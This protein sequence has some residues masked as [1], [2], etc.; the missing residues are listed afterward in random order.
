MTRQF[1]KT[2][3]SACRTVTPSKLTWT[4]KGWKR[5]LAT[6]REVEVWDAAKTKVPESNDFNFKNRHPELALIQEAHNEIMYGNIGSKLDDLPQ[7]LRDILQQPDKWFLNKNHSRFYSVCDPVTQVYEHG[8]WGTDRSQA[9]AETLNERPSASR[10]FLEAANI[11]PLESSTER[12]TDILGAIAYDKDGRDPNVY[13]SPYATRMDVNISSLAIREEDPLL[14]EE[15]SGDDVQTSLLHSDDDVVIRKDPRAA[16]LALPDISDEARSNIIE[17][18]GKFKELISKAKTEQ[19]YNTLVLTYE[20]ALD[21]EIGTHITTC[22]NSS[23]CGHGYSAPRRHHDPIKLPMVQDSTAAAEERV[24]FFYQ[25]LGE[26]ASCS[27]FNDLFGPPIIDSK[28]GRRSNP[29]GFMGKI[30]SMYHHDKEIWAKWSIHDVVDKKTGKIIY[31]SAF[32]IAREDFIRDY[33][34]KKKGDEEK[35]R[36]A[37]WVRFD[38]EETII[39]GIRDKNGK[40]VQKF[41]HY[42]DSIWR[43]KRTKA[44]MDA[45]LTKKQWDSV[46][47]MIGIARKRIK[48]VHPDS[49]DRQAALDKL[50]E[51]FRKVTNLYDLRLYM[52][53]AQKRRFIERYQICGWTKKKDGTLVTDKDGNKIPQLRSVPTYDFRPSILDRISIIDEAR[54]RKSCAKKKRYLVGREVLYQQL[55]EQVISSKETDIEISLAC[56]KQRCVS[57]EEIQATKENPAK[58]IQV[59][60]A[61]AIGKLKWYEI[62]KDK[63]LLGLECDQ[64]GYIVW[65]L[66]HKEI[67]KLKTF[68]EATDGL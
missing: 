51:F 17:L 30:R 59:I 6:D 31:R 44:L 54:W 53:W 61:M 39:P 55:R 7:V 26:A 46:Y 56:T 40:L 16:A 63:G 3:H 49:K 22:I 27:S 66:G 33:R 14:G 11:I 9:D 52:A 36:I 45:C 20:Q 67:P 13:E 5:V 57:K 2:R 15:C 1:S 32:N 4:K 23:Y 68:E 65:H 50:A 37:V 12:V 35:L 62:E 47:K 24:A 41:K 8:E 28:T 25:L 21:R 29:G 38:R 60:P 10:L 18:H 43:Q 58:Q 64:C 42:R 34:E 48:P 19:E